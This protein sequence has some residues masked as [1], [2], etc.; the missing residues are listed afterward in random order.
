MLIIPGGYVNIG[1]TPQQALIREYMEETHIEI[2][3]TDIIGIRFNKD[4]IV[5]PEQ[6]APQNGNKQKREKHD[7]QVGVAAF[8]KRRFRL[9][10]KRRLPEHNVAQGSAA[11]TGRK[12]DDNRAE[13]VE[14]LG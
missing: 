11:A 1:E 8:P 13:K 12:A 4:R 14:A 2:K 6:V 3:P 5:H 10:P 9:H 7:E